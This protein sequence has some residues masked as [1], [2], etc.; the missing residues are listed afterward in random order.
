M[1]KQTL[2][3][4]NEL[5]ASRQPHAVATV[6]ETNGSVSAKLGAK[7]VIAADG[8]V[9]AGW[10]GG[11][12]AE[13]A[14]CQ[15]AI[16]CI[17]SGSPAVID[18]DMDDEVLGV[19]MP[20]GGTMRV[21]VEPEL[22]SPTLWIIGHG[23]IAEVLCELGSTMGLEVVV[24]DAM[25][26]CE[27]FSRADRLIAD[28]VTMA[29]FQPQEGDF[30]VIATQHKGDHRTIK[31]ALAAGTG[32]IALIA[33]RKRAK[34]VL[35]YLI[36]EGFS[37][38]DLKRVTAPAGIDLGARTPEE[39]ALS[40]MAE[41]VMVRRAGSGKPMREVVGLGDVQESAFGT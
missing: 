6:V 2:Y 33:S 31:V 16:D 21:Y 39:I 40:L 4:L 29:E 1:N 24:H 5:A 19:G 14:V 34:L 3:V 8:R 10:V 36:E 37:A 17:E 7:A 41:I 27:K 23:R 20:C 30:A 28:D 25:A 22:P 12:C 13:S 11:G 38:E 15:Q 32:Y 35:D 18:I 26:N 9:I